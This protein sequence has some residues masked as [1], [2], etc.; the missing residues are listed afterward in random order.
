M[1]TQSFP[2]KSLLR[3]DQVASTQEE[4]KNLEAKLVNKHIE[5]K[6]EVQ[7]Q[8]RRAKKDFENQVPLPPE[9]GEEEGRMVRRSKE[10][11][12]EIIPGMCSQEE[13]RKAPPGAV[14]KHMAWEKRNK[15][16]ILEWKHIMCRLTAGSGNRDAANLEKHRPRDSTLSMDNAQIPGKQFFMPETA[17]LAVRFSDE[18]IAA[19]RTLDPE[20][21]D[22][23]STLTNKQ[24]T[25]V[26]D[27]VEGIGLKAPD[28]V[29]SAAGKLGV[30]MREA[31]K[32]RNRKPLTPEQKDALL[33]RLADARAKKAAMKAQA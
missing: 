16:R 19:L 18:Q 23:L 13:M 20:L 15:A 9:T 1:Q 32:K 30:R 17:G 24:R 8:L 6:G 28:P 3:P 26:K 2:T 29:Q 10:L 27:I 25:Q 21:A 14:D 31:K 4:I 33:K 22:R 5:D 11:L 12:T 7:R